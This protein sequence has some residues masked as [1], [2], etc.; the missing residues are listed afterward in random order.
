M[1]PLLHTHTSTLPTQAFRLFSARRRIQRNAGAVATLT[2]YVPVFRARLALLR[3]RRAAAA[4]QAVVRRRQVQA[5]VATVLRRVTLVQVGVWKGGGVR[6]KLMVGKGRGIKSCRT[7]RSGLTL[8]IPGRA[9]ATADGHSRR[10]AHFPWSTTRSHTAMAGTHSDCSTTALS[11]PASQ[12]AWRGCISRKRAGC[13]C[14]SW[15]RRSSSTESITRQSTQTR[16]TDVCL[17]LGLPTSPTGSLAG[18]HQ[19]EACWACCGRGAAPAAG[20]RGR[21]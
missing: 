3:A 6:G 18:L 21:L 14:L 2:R 8:F 17:L 11:Q 9:V 12:A 4:I 1:S 15:A 13:I 10:S 19:P 5:H 7:G 20:R 16:N